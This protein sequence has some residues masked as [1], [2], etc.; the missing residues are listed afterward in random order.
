[1]PATTTQKTAFER[2]LDREAFRDALPAVVALIVAHAVISQVTLDA[3][4]HWW[5]GTIALIP[6]LPLIWLGWAQWRSIQRADELQRMSQLQALAI[7]FAVSMIVASAGGLLL[8]ASVGTGP[9]YLQLTFVTGILA[10]A[11]ALFVKLSR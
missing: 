5:H 10:W 9:M 4:K 8:V 6:T 2:K 1:M 7:G 3:D 11:A